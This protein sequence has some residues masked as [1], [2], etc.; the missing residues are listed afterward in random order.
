MNIPAGNGSFSIKQTANPNNG[1]VVASGGTVSNPAG[2][3][4]GDYTLTM[5]AP[6]NT[7]SIVDASSAPVA[8]SPFSYESGNT[9][10]F[11]GMSIS[12]S[13]T[14]ADGQTFSVSTGQ[15]DSVFATVQ[16][17]IDNLKAPYTT[18]ADKAATETENNQLTMQL[19][20]AFDNITKYRADLGARLNQLQSTS[21][22]QENLNLITQETLKQLR[23][24]DPISVAT[25][26]NLQLTN[27]QAA[28]KS[29]VSIQNLSVFNYIS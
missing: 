5:N 1:T 8:G 16:R 13:G 10:S 12:L 17:M 26:Y 20:N 15:N 21:T 25:N 19:G 14:I 23:E 3:V 18:P 2:F 22:S 7:V 6:A 9:I 4:P 11:N 27:L 28:Q 24:I 29:F